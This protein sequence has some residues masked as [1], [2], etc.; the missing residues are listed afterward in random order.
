M[1]EPTTIDPG[2]AGSP[3]PH[4][5]AISVYRGGPYLVRGAFELIGPDGAAVALRRRTIALCRCGRSARAPFCDGAHK[6]LPV[7]AREAAGDAPA[8]P[9]PAA[10]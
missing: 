5:C 8:P 7:M 4:P 2:G 9:P 3:D 6:R 1:S 10:A